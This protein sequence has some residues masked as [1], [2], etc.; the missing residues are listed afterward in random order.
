MGFKTPRCKTPGCP[1]RVRAHGMCEACYH[2]EWLSAQ[3]SKPRKR[4]KSDDYWD[5]NLRL[6]ET[7]YNHATTVEARLRLRGQLEILR[8]VAN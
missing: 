4:R 5:R 8:K 1:R 3:R 6:L 2:R 7:A